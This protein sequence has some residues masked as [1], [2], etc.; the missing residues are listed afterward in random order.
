MSEK[1]ALKL[2]LTIIGAAM[3]LA[4]IVGMV[5]TILVNRSRRKNGGKELNPGPIFIG[6]ILL[7]SWGACAGM[8]AF[9]VS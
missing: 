7:A 4:G 3:I 2:L 9:A 5:R 1:E 8:W 6:C